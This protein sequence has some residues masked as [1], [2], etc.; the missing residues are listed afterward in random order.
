MLTAVAKEQPV[1]D[2]GCQIKNKSWMVQTCT[3]PSHVR[4][5]RYLCTNELGK[6]HPFNCLEKMRPITSVGH[7]QLRWL[8][9]IHF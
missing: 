4:W 3:R 7:V 8:V 2:A 6:N 1:L 5:D 9:R